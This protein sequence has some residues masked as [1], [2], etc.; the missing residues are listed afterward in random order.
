MGD[1]LIA[2]LQR[3]PVQALQTTVVFPGPGQYQK[4]LIVGLLQRLPDDDLIGLGA[5]LPVDAVYRVAGAVL[6]QLMLLRIAP[7][8]LGF[9]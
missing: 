2:Q 4:H 7:P 9:S 3:Q 8:Y 5:E 6:P 1:I